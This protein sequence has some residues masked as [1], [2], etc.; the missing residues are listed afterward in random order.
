MFFLYLQCI[1]SIIGYYNIAFVRFGCACIRKA[2]AL[3]FCSWRTGISQIQSISQGMT[4]RMTAGCVL[5][6][7]PILPLSLDFSVKVNKV[8]RDVLFISAWDCTSS[9]LLIWAMR[10]PQCV[11]WLASKFSTLFLYLAID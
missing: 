5:K 7:I 1:L 8:Y 4:R 3:T 10:E 2:F 11:E 9:V 6:Y